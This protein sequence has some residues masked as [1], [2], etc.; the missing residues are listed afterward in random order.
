MTNMNKCETLATCLCP[1]NGGDINV[2]IDI[3]FARDIPD[4]MW[5][6]DRE[7]I[8]IVKYKAVFFLF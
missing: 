1:T 6:Y 7:F 2:C 5:S 3:L 4:E 8:D